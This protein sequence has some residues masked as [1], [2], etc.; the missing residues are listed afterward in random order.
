M[1]CFKCEMAISDR[2]IC[3]IVRQWRHVLSQ[4]DWEIS[5]EAASARWR[6]AVSWLKITPCNERRAVSKSSVDCGYWQITHRAVLR[7][8]CTGFLFIFICLMSFGIWLGLLLI[9]GLLLCDSDMY[10]GGDSSS[11]LQTLSYTCSYCGQMGFSITLLLEHIRASHGANSGTSSAEVVG[12][13]TVLS[14]M[15]SFCLFTT[16]AAATATATLDFYL[17]GQFHKFTFI[18]RCT[19]GSAA[20]NWVNWVGGWLGGWV[21]DYLATAFLGRLSKLT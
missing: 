17:T 11:T 13:L 2:F 15:S 6:H 19:W 18:C 12:S 4:L 20:S 10:Y 3:L 9:L 21:G 14:N 5:N 1:A 7:A 8:L 16:S